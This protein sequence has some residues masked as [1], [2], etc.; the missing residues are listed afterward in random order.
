MFNFLQRD[1]QQYDKGCLKFYMRW[2]SSELSLECYIRHNSMTTYVL[3][4]IAG[5]VKFQKKGSAIILLNSL[6]REWS[7]PAVV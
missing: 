1:F 4:H 5:R 6:S 7:A 2:K 3:M